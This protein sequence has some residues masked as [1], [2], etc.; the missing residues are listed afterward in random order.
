MVAL[1]LSKYPRILAVALNVCLLLSIANAKKEEKPLPPGFPETLKSD[2]FDEEMQDGLHIVEFFSPYCSHCKGLAPIWQDTWEKFTNENEGLDIS[3]NQ[4]NCVESGDL[5][6]K[7]RVDYFPD[8]RLYG[9]YGFIKHFPTSTKRTVDNLIGFAKEEVIKNS[10]WEPLDVEAQAQKIDAALLDSIVSGD[11]PSPYIIS[12]LPPRDPKA[13]EFFLNCDD[14]SPFERTWKI[15]LGKLSDT[16]IKVGYVD[17]GENEESCLEL[18]I[19][20]ISKLLNPKIPAQPQVLMIVPNQNNIYNNITDNIF[21]YK[22]KMSLIADD[23]EEFARRV[24]HNFITPKIKSQQILE[25]MDTKLAFPVS[26]FL[27]FPKQQK[28]LIFIQRKITLDDEE[29]AFLSS[30]LTS[31]ADIPDVLLYRATRGVAKQI[32]GMQ[33]KETFSHLDLS[34]AKEE[35]ISIMN[36]API[37]AQFVMVKDGHSFPEMYFNS[38]IIGTEQNKEEVLSFVQKNLLDTFT[39]L[40]P[41]YLKKLMNFKGDINTIAIQI[42]DTSDPES[43]DLSNI[44]FR[45]IMEMS[46]FVEAEEIEIFFDSF[47][48]P[49]NDGIR[50]RLPT[51][52][53]DNIK[54]LQKRR[55]IL[56]YLDISKQPTLLQHIGIR[57]NNP[58]QLGNTILIDIN[59]RHYYMSDYSGNNFNVDSPKQLL[60]AISDLSV[61]YDGSPYSGSLLGSPY[62]GSFSWM[63]N[64]HQYGV[65][66]YMCIVISIYMCI[67]YRRL[68]RIIA[69]SLPRL[70]KKA[71]SKSPKLTTPNVVRKI[72][73]FRK[74]N[75][76]NSVGL[77]GKHNID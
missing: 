21:E 23:Y 54:S 41:K 6:N 47:K 65:L 16:D 28:H 63:D 48:M 10:N 3:F 38:D 68:P 17:C 72:I 51:I 58:S 15:L 45:T 50:H 64:V 4:V 25:T 40:T 30:L 22:K 66:G 44:A 61:Y 9:P 29:K 73:F 33:D 1:R 57:E 36:A 49:D 8:I 7:E 27:S 60:D 13:N 62:Y 26:P 31:L 75:S 18:G 69:K 2:T 11:A 24:N 70:L 53:L 42:V 67:K 12:F 20:S 74:K 32:F 52:S 14:C 5:C 19:P 35:F 59:T 37:S 55:V 56:C 43:V 71:K 34:I 39:E 76:R 46:E 77:L